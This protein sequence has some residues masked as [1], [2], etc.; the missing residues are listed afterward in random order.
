MGHSALKFCFMSSV[1]N[2]KTYQIMVL[3]VCTILN[4]A[5][6]SLCTLEYI[7]KDEKSGAGV[8]DLQ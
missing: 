6:L 8:V 2:E 1:S 4:N 3:N 5:T 7:K